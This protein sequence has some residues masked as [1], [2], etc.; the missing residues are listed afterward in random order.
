M[1]SHKVMEIAENLYRK[2]YVSYP[3]TETDKFP[4]TMNLK[5]ITENFRNSGEYGAYVN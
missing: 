1:T 2:G 3:R 4:Y 5:N